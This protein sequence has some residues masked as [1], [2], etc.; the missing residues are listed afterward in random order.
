MNKT[1]LI[2]I[3]GADHHGHVGRLLSFVKA[4]GYEP[5]KITFLITQLIRLMRNKQEVKMSKRTGNSLTMQQMYEMVG[6][7]A[8]R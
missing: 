3:F 4:V 2:N 1:K 8:L 7:N 6:Y 5:D